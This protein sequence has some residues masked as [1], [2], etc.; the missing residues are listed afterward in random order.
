MLV[1]YSGILYFEVTFGLQ[2]LGGTL[3]KKIVGL[4]KKY[5]ISCGMS[6][7]VDK[8]IDYCQLLWVKIEVFLT[9]SIVTTLL[10][11]I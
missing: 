7:T 5:W 3:I 6:V 8:V 9:P 1:L 10:D 4:L 2:I 11:P